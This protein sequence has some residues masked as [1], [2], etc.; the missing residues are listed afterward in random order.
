MVEVVPIASTA[1]R[2][3]LPESQPVAGG[4]LVRA[5]QTSAG[6]TPD[7]ATGRN[8]TGGLPTGSHL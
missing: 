2:M 5:D 8:S 3:L 7:C 6:I 1:L 4:S